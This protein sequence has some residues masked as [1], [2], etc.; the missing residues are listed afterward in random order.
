MT[1]DA[2]V[3]TGAL[4]N[5]MNFAVQLVAGGRIPRTGP[6]GRGNQGGRQPSAPARGLAAGRGRGPI[7]VDLADLAPTPRRRRSS[8]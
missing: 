6:A 3:N 4:L 5:R 1:A 7:Q 2:W 8:T